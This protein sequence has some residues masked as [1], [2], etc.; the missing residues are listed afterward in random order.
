MKCY[1]DIIALAFELID[2]QWTTCFS[3][4]FGKPAILRNNFEIGINV[5]LISNQNGLSTMENETTRMPL[6]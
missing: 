1:D 2:F 6:K 4:L 5:T 3:L